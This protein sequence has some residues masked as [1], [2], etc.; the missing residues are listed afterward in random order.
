[1]TQQMH[2]AGTVLYVNDLAAVVKFYQRAFGF[3]VSFYDPT[4]GFAM[5]HKG[6]SLGIASHDLAETLM[7]DAY[8]RPFCGHSTGVEIAFF[9]NDVTASFTA[10]LAEG[11]IGLSSPRKMSWG[12]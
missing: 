2:F 6:T 10:A 8:V 12:L 1:M 5:L 11:C 9:T 7:P 3:Q 4:L